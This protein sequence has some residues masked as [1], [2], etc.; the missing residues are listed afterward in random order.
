MVVPFVTTLLFTG[1]SYLYG[2][3]VY[4]FIVARMFEP[5][6]E[7]KVIH[8]GLGLTAQG[9]DLFYASSPSVEDSDQFNQSCAS[10]E[11]TA[12]I[13]GCYYKRTIYIYNVTN[14]ELAQ[15]KDAS[16]AHEML[17][18]A[19]ERLT[20]I[21]KSRVDSML[22]A[23]YAKLK[24]DAELNKLMDYYRQ[25][26]PGALTNELHSIIGTTIATI[27]P[28]LE[29]YYRRYFT[30]RQKIV[31]LNTAYSS[32]FTKIEDQA[33]ALSA[34]IDAI[35]PQLQADLTAY[36]TDITRLN[37]DISAFNTKVQAG[38]FT[39]QA[40]FSEAQRALTGRV[41]DMNV[42]RSDI[43]VRVAEYNEYIAELKRLSVK[44][45]ELN[46]SINGI[47]TPEASL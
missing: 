16:A 22:Q 14:A 5:S 27:S 6:P 1:L 38:Y 46:N 31:A 42:R 35:H 13:L 8:D 10:A 30:D 11:R 12:A 19:Y 21:D 4:D 39:T 36:N 23:E 45:T 18:A 43:N 37:D 26:E 40:A 41:N 29:A 47:A 34:K 28:D 3:R 25:A 44:V 32:V 24:G 7:V 33:N 9:S 20:V 2:A 17:H 15:A